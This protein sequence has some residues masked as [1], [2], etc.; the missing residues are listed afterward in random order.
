[1][2]LELGKNSHLEVVTTFVC[3]KEAHRMK[4]FLCIKLNTG[5]QFCAFVR[6]KVFIM[7]K[8]VS[9]FSLVIFLPKWQLFFS[10]PT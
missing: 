4:S 10:E 1:M 5:I 9:K 8:N 6:I 7:L 3:Q 2:R